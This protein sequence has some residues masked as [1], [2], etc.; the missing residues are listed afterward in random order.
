MQLFHTRH[1][2]VDVRPSFM[3]SLTDL[4]LE[5]LDLYLI[6]A[7][8]AVKVCPDFSTPWIYSHQCVHGLDNRVDISYY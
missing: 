6:H 3:E 7:P 5:Y 8:I 4:G 1:N 2:P